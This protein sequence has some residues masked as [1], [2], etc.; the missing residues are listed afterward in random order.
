MKFEASV[1]C[2][3]LE[4]G[5]GVRIPKSKALYLSAAVFGILGGS[6]VTADAAFKTVTVQT[7]GHQRVIRGFTFGSLK[8]FL[9]HN[10]VNVPSDARVDVNLSDPVKDG[11]HVDVTLPKQITVVD[12]T[13]VMK[14]TTFEKTVSDMFQRQGIQVRPLDSVNVSIDSQLHDGEQIK[15]D[16]MT[17]KVTT[18]RS[19]VPFQTVRRESS[20][21]NRGETRVLTHGV[22]GVQEVKTTQYYLNGSSL[23][24]AVSKSMV[25][26]PRDEVIEVGTREPTYQLSSRSDNPL[27]AATGK[28]LVVEAT[29]YVA[30]GRTSSGHLARPGVIAVDPSVIPLGSRVY[31][32]GVGT[33]LAADTGGA[34]RGNRIDICLATRSQAVGFGRKT[35][36]VY[37]DG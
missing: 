7:N 29:A 19:S 6:A 26:R 10:G 17:K 15:I 32:P 5:D 25:K 28:Q 35:I 3:P 22:K 9:N 31:I 2:K 20:A 30:G 18:K 1:A 34:I 27:L 23:K 24:H 16:R 33:M 11:M 21:L 37:I 14:V 8:P 13:H 4:R 36:T 12:G